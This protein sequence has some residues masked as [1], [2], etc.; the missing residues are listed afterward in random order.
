MLPEVWLS[1]QIHVNLL[2][3]NVNYKFQLAKA[4]KICENISFE[5]WTFQ[6]LSNDF[7]C[8]CACVC[9]CVFYFVLL[10]RI[11][12][13]S[14]C[15]NTHGL[16]LVSLLVLSLCVDFYCVTILASWNSFVFMFFFLPPP[17]F[18]VSRIYSTPPPSSIFQH[19]ILIFW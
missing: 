8:A 14:N 7:H 11:Y 17:K 5:L 10:F 9:V 12:P 1:R 4:H 16:A 15:K 13:E 19:R 6:K 3:V 18:T 2:N